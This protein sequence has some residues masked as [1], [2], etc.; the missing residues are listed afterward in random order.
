MAKIFVFLDQYWM[1]YSLKRASVDLKGLAYLNRADKTA[2]QDTAN[3]NYTS[4]LRKE[5]MPYTTWG[6]DIQGTV[7]F[8]S[9]AKLTLGAA[10]KQAVWDYDDDY[11]ASAR[12]VGA[13]GEQQFISPFANIDFRFLDESLIINLGA[14]Y[15]WI[16]TSDGANRD[17]QGR[18]VQENRPITINTAVKQNGQP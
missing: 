5:K 3:D 11:V 13:E 7:P 8:R 17:S 4:L 9:W 16:E 12:D 14:R 2:Y 6:A 1:K 18:A 15:D 10:Y